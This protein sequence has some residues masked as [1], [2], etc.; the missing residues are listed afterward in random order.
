MPRISGVNIPEEKRIEVA[1]TYIYGIGKSLS[2]RILDNLNIDKNLKA[3][4]LSFDQLNSLKKEIEKNYKIE[5]E[6]RHEIISNIKRLKET[7]T[8]RGLRHSKNLPVRGQQTRT[9]SRT[10]R[11][12]IRRTMGSGKRTVEKT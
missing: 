6:L 8:Y 2:Q 9:N 7:G 4:K 12:N 10:V 1:L 5:G 11:G 3:N